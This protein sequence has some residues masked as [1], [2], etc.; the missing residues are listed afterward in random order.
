MNITLVP[1]GNAKES[2]Q[3]ST[4]TWTCQHGT[5]ECFGNLL[6]VFPNS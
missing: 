6:E 3:G 2:Q 1:Y 5:N 4:Y